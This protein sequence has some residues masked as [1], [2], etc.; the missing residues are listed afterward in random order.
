MPFSDYIEN[1]QHAGRRDLYTSFAKRMAY[2]QAFINFTRDD[3]VTFN[4][5]SKYLRAAIPMLTHRLYEKLLEFDITARALRTRST[6]SDAPVDDYFTIDSPHVQRRKVFWKWYLTRF[7]QDPS[8]L[9]YWQYLEKV[10]TMHNGQILMHPLN[11]EYIHMNAC[12][13]YLKELLLETISLSPDM[14][15]PFKFAFIRSLSKILCIQNDLIAKCHI[16]DGDEYLDEPPTTAAADDQPKN[17]KPTAAETETSSPHEVASPMPNPRNSM[18]FSIPSLSDSRSPSVV[19][20][21]VSR[22]GFGRVASTASTTVSSDAGSISSNHQLTPEYRGAVPAI[23]SPF[24]AEHAQTFE[25]TIWS[26]KGKSK[27]SGYRVR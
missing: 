4:K 24:V 27:G 18:H 22:E 19:D 23:V 3:I 13:G 8:K 25:T 14:S 2:I 15:V 10:G 9:E 7:C 20:S 5:G 17:V 1:I 6:A 26:E 16:R 11:I 12:L 21:P